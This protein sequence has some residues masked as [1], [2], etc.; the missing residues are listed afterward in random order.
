M[1]AAARGLGTDKVFSKTGTRK[2]CRAPMKTSTF[3]CSDDVFFNG[4]GS[5]R[6]GDKVALHPAS[7]CGPDLST[8]STSSSRVFVNK[9][10]A[11]RIGDR[12]G[13]DN[14]IISGSSTVFIG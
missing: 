2:R 9:K 8:L 5:V 6:I 10:G 3:E 4:V 7:G 13:N 1:P 11:G 12:Y 14:I